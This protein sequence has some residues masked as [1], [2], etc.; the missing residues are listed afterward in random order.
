MRQLLKQRIA[1]AVSAFERDEMS[2][3]PEALTVNCDEASLVVV[4][5]GLAS[6]AERRYGREP[7]AREL[8]SRFYHELFDATKG[9]LV[10]AIEGILERPVA[11]AAL[12]V[13][14][15]SRDGVFVFKLEAS[16]TSDE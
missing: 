2:V 3:T 7:A 4:V 8:L 15:E 13:D 10:A 11:S 6:E 9:A 16:P 1:E 14:S 5:H 12:S